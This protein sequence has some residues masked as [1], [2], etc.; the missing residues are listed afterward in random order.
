MNEFVAK[1][2]LIVSGT[3]LVTGSVTSSVGFSGSGANITGVVSS[4]YAVSSSW[5]PGG[6]SVSASYATTASYATVAQTLLGSVVSA[7]YAATASVSITSSS[8]AA[9]ASYLE[10]AIDGGISGTFS[11]S[12][13]QIFGIVTS[14]YASTVTGTLTIGMALDIGPGTFDSVNPE[15]LHISASNTTSTTPIGVN[16]NVNNYFQ[17]NIQNASGGTTASS[18]F[19]ATN[20]M[21][22]QT[23]NY[24]DMGINSSGFVAQNAV[25]GAYDAYLYTT[26]S[27]GD[28]YIGNAGPASRIKFFA[29]SMDS[30][31][32][33]HLTISSSGQIIIGTGSTETT[34]IGTL[35]FKIRET[36]PTPPPFGYMEMYSRNFAGRAIPSFVGPAN[37]PTPIQPGLFNN[38]LSLISP[39]GTTAMSVIGNSVT[40]VGTISHT[41]LPTERIGYMPNIASGAG[42]SGTV[43]SASIALTNTSVA[44]GQSASGSGGFFFSARMGFPDSS[45]TASAN[46]DSS[47]RMFVGLTSATMNGVSLNPSTSIANGC[48]FQLQMPTGD[49]T[50]SFVC[51]DGSTLTRQT[52]TMGFDNVISNNLVS[53]SVYDFYIFSPPS[54]SYVGWRIDNVLTGKTASGSMS[55][56]LPTPLVFMRGG[57]DASG[58]GRVFNYRLQRVYLES[59]R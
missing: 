11:G 1:K 16:G 13:A 6:S 7:S 4:S 10:G 3:A 29:G 51:R 20:D 22:T 5:S 17:M 55:G 2:G 59:D 24:V 21:G 28:L 53:Q 18:D 57:F 8:Y 19:V 48:G 35:M 46:Q 41:S 40:S 47:S 54:A 49:T 37:V 34:T 56:T 30:A 27:V 43:I 50:W 44:R 23:S 42:A 45:Y 39:G 9:T 36:A 12:G 15:A 32:S 58:R 33:T 52:T 14:S 26:S 31:A 38:N 25:G